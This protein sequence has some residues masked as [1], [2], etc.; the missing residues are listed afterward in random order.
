MIGYVF[1]ASDYNKIWYSLQKQTHVVVLCK[2]ST[3]MWCYMLFPP[4]R[5]LWH[6]Q[7]C[8][9]SGLCPARFIIGLN[10]GK[11]WS[12][13]VAPTHLIQADR[14]GTSELCDVSRSTRSAWPILGSNIGQVC[15]NL[16]SSRV[17]PWPSRARGRERF[18]QSHSTLPS[19]NPRPPS[20][21]PRQATPS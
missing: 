10:L 16:D 11:V 2:T 3:N 9:V 15:V 7:P 6:D 13:P 8:D 4:T 17:L 20:P 18:G 19:P 21:P 14:C 12:S 5:P 1:C